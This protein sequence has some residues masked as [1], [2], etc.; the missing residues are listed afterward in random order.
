MVSRTGDHG[1]ENAL[2]MVPDFRRLS[3]KPSTLL[4]QK[5]TLVENI[6]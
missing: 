6:L 2:N 4:A 1:R 3:V 5:G